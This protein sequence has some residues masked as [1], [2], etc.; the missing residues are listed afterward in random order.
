MRWRRVKFCAKCIPPLIFFHDRFFW[1]HSV[2]GRSMTPTLNPQNTFWERAFPDLV[3]VQKSCEYERG[4]VVVYS[5]PTTRR[6][7]RQTIA[8]HRGRRRAGNIN[9][10]F[11]ANYFD[12]DKF[13]S[14]FI[15]F[16][17]WRRAAGITHGSR[18]GT[19]G[20]R[21]IARSI[22]ST[23]ARR[24]RCRWGSSPASSS[25]WFGRFGGRASSTAYLR[26][27]TACKSATAATH[28]RRSTLCEIIKLL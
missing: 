9:L 26:A 10:I 1:A 27:R 22:A 7:R 2:S 14:N 23:R 17:R 25:R 5:D 28:R 8:S 20:W 21:V 13:W 11:K 6:E 16:C 4:D 3:L 12:F 24:G 15:D 18:A 19:A